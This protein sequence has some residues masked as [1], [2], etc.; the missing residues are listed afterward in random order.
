MTSL[1]AD[2][3]ADVRR[4]VESRL[5]TDVIA[6]LTTVRP[7]GQ[8]ET[9]PVWF[10]WTGVEILIYSRPNK[11]KLTNLERN[12]MVAVV[13]D[14]TKGGYDVVRV[15]GTARYIADYPALHE[16]SAY[17]EKYGERIRAAGYKGPEAFASAFSAA[18][19]V[20]PSKIRT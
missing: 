3:P 15:E 18:V 2:V 6:W 17:L 20:T 19:V 7:S 8:P 4:H 1:M 14:D 13:L 10:L 11:A 5:S 9:V 16:V 12:A